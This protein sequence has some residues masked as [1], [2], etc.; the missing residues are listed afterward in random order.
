M[1]FRYYFL[2]FGLLAMF[3]ACKQQEPAPTER[4]SAPSGKQVQLAPFNLM[5]L[6]DDTMLDR[7]QLQGQV[8]LVNFFATWCPPCI[9]E[10]PSFIALQNKY[11]AK[12]FT[13][14][15]FSADQGTPEQ[16]KKFIKKHAINYPVFPAIAEVTSGFGG[17]TG[18][19][20]TFLINRKG[21]VVKK[22]IGYVEHDVLDEEI[23][24][25]IAP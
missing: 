10:I 13:V 7:K 8:L 9:Q 4:Y 3:V 5:S 2:I 24:K 6:T 20:V 19:P 21:E 23:V 17:V 15:A 1:K 14:V 16:I 25:L 12:G 18:I 11:K 22:L